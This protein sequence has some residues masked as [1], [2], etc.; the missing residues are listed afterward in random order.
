MVRFT[1]PL[2]ASQG[3]QTSLPVPVASDVQGLRPSS[4]PSRSVRGPAG[5]P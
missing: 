3:C 2:S 5:F 1:L 4:S